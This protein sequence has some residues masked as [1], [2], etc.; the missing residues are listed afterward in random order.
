MWNGKL[1]IWGLLIVATALLAGYIWK[2][3]GSTELS[4]SSTTLERVQAY[5][6]E[7][8]RM[9]ISEENFVLFLR[10]FKA[11]QELEVWV[12]NAKTEAYQHLLTYPICKNSGDLGPKRKEGDLQ[13]PEGFYHIDRMNPNSSYHLS[14]GLNYPNASDKIRG[15]Q[16]QPG[17]DI[18]IHGG[19]VTV[20]C[21]PI[22]DR[23]IEE[24]YMLVTQ[25]QKNGQQEVPVHI[26][27]ARLASPTFREDLSTSPHQLFWQE[28]LPIYQ[29]FEQYRTLPSIKIGTD[30]SYQL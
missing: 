16:D 4:P 14:M 25:A 24:L 3:R 5:Y 29:Y 28:L 9:G 18:F 21:L 15:D 11:E 30:G 1:L 12:S 17:S 27:P 23:K 6:A 13:V 8:L 19:C 20:G 26:F 10:A 7:I 2:W 22:T